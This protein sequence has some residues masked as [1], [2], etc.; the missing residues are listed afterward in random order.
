MGL[1]PFLN[2]KEVS[3]PHQD[4]LWCQMNE[5]SSYQFI[6]LYYN[7]QNCCNSKP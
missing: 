2:M 6:F 7:D 1:F 4:I 5:I 3:S